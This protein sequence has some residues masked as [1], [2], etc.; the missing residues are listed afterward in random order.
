ME[1]NN[2]PRFKKDDWIVHSYHGV[3]RIEGIDRKCLEGRE[4]TFFKVKTDDLTYWLPVNAID[5]QHIRAISSVSTLNKALTTIRRKPK[6]LGSDY[7]IRKARITEI[8]NNSSLNA[9]A[10]LI[11]D[12]NGRCAKHR[13]NIYEENML[14]KLKQQFVDELTVATDCSQAEAKKKLEDALQTSVSK[15]ETAA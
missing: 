12:L 8:F 15:M 2:A 13:D 3:S 14:D 7:R 9:K 5:V 1:D 6:K 11:R 10:E 4:R